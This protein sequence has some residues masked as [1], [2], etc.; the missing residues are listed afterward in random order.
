MAGNM[1]LATCIWGF[2]L[3]GGLCGD[4]FFFICMEGNWG[5]LIDGDL[6][7]GMWDSY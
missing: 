1:H 6:H 5:F 7:A 3:D 2:H 4:L